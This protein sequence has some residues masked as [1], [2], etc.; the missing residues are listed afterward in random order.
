[1]LNILL[2]IDLNRNSNNSNGENLRLRNS[3]KHSI[4]V[5][6]MTL[7]FI[8]FTCPSAICSQFYSVLVSSYIG[9]VILYA[10]DCFAFS[11]H[12]LNIIILCLS[13]KQFLKKIKEAFGIKKDSNYNHATLVW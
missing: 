8:I 10:C 6:I 5:I 12:A 13:S 7:L 4:T 2:I 3:K 11:Y 1:M 9:K